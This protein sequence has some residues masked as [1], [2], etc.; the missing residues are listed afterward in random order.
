MRSGRESE[1]KGVANAWRQTETH[2]HSKNGKT[3]QVY[4][5]TTSYLVQLH[6]NSRTV[7][8]RKIT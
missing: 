5:K 1:R 4:F 2:I 8:N 6:S 7:I 3:F